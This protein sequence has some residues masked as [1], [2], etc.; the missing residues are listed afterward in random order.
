[1]MFEL[2]VW[3]YL[4]QSCLFLLQWQNRTQQLTAN[5]P[6]SRE[7]QQRY[8][9]WQQRYLRYYEFTTPRVAE[10]GSLKPGTGDPAHDLM[11][12]EQ[13][14]VRSFQ[15]WLA[16]GETRNIQQCIWEEGNR[17]LHQL[18]NNPSALKDSSAQLIEVFLTIDAPDLA[19]LPWER[20]E[21]TPNPSQLPLRIIRT[22]SQGRLRPYSPSYRRKPRILVILGEDTNLSLQAHWQALQ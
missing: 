9:R 6:Y 1:M 5:V 18:V 13:E 22:A 4:D 11:Q 3:Y 10:S 7:V 2:Q 19:K 14:L 16:E 15:A 8:Q 21:L 12:A 20:W 17:L